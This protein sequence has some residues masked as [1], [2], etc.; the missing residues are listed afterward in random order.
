LEQLDKKLHPM[1]ERDAGFGP[2]PL[3]SR[4]ANSNWDFQTGCQTEPLLSAEIDPD[5]QVAEKGTDDELRTTIYIAEE[6]SSIRTGI[7][8]Q[9]SPEAIFSECKSFARRRKSWN[10]WPK[11]SADLFRKL[12]HWVS[13]PGSS[14]FVVKADRCVGRRKDL[15]ARKRAKDFAVEVT[16]FL[17][18][19]TNHRV[20]WTFSSSTHPHMSVTDVL[21]ILIHQACRFSLLQPNILPS[22]AHNTEN[23]L[24]DSLRTILSQL[25]RCFIIIETTNI[26]ATARFLQL[27]Q[28]TVDKSGSMIK[29]LVVSYGTA[30]EGLSDSSQNNNIIVATVQRPPRSRKPMSRHRARDADWKHLDPR[31]SE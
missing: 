16:D 1:A 15:H 3:Q 6:Q 12:Q 18:S 5:V 30:S 23:E 31:F 8:H 29:M 2:P 21:N 14:L 7:C 25:S 19:K 24:F 13:T 10:L 22:K 27:S 28:D 26:E 17:K 9:M 4:P 11:G 20:I